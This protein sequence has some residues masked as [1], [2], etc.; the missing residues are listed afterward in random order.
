MKKIFLKYLLSFGLTFFSSV[1][2]A[3]HNTPE[4]QVDQVF[5]AWDSDLIQVSLDGVGSGSADNPANCSQSSPFISSS[6]FSVETR[7]LQASMLMT[8]YSTGKPVILVIHNSLCQSGRPV[9]RAV[10]LR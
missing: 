8:A 9:I 4:A 7:Q 10:Q 2:S 3:Q 6:S 1:A 5:S